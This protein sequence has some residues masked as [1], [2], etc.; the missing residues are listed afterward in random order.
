MFSSNQHITP[1]STPS[2]SLTPQQIQKQVIFYQSIITAAPAAPSLIWMAALHPNSFCGCEC[3]YACVYRKTDVQLKWFYGH[4]YMFS[5]RC[6]GLHPRQCFQNKKW[7]DLQ[8]HFWKSLYE[9][10]LDLE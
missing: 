10:Q 5:S 3:F 9:K 6:G 4:C 1:V 2:L 7:E 8:Y